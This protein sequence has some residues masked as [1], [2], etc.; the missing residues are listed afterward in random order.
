VIVSH[1]YLALIDMR[2]T[3]KENNTTAKE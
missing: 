1:F 2:A 3:I